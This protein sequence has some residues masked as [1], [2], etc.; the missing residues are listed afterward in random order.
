MKFVIQQSGPTIGLAN[1][2]IVYAELPADI[3]L[4]LVIAGAGVNLRCS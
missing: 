4:L 1:H 2:R 3:S